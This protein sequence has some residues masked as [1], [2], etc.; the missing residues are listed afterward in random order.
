P[1]YRPIHFVR[2]EFLDILRKVVRRPDVTLHVSN[3]CI[4]DSHLLDSLPTLFPQSIPTG[5]VS[6]AIASNVLWKRL[7]GQM[8]NRERDIFKK[9]AVGI[10]FRMVLEVFNRVIDDGDRGVV[11]AIGFDRRP[12]LTILRIPLY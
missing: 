2:T 4:D 12:R 9:G 1:G 6:I 8:G 11:A 5:A 7:Q 3:R 10:F